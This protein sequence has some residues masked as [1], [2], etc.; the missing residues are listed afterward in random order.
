MVGETAENLDMFECHVGVDRPRH[1]AKALDP[2]RHA[3][4]TTVAEKQRLVG[5]QLELYEV[6]P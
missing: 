5:K 4:V 1:D 6:E 2:A 3:F